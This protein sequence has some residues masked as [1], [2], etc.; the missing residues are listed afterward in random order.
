ME[1]TELALGQLLDGLFNL[2]QGAHESILVG[3]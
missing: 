2:K 1:F 3:R